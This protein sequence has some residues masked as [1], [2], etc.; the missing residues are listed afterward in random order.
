M[1]AF[2]PSYYQSTPLM[3]T[4]LFGGQCVPDRGGL[5]LLYFVDIQTHTHT[6]EHHNKPCPAEVVGFNYFVYVQVIQYG[7]ILK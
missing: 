1:N 3:R 4:E 7:N 2:N 5:L 6:Q